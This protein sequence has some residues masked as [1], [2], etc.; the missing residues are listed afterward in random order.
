MC[1]PVA[2]DKCGVDRANLKAWMIC[3]EWMAYVAAIAIDEVIEPAVANENEPQEADETLAETIKDEN[4]IQEFKCVE[5]FEGRIVERDFEAEG[6]AEEKDE[7]LESE[8]VAG[9]ETV[10][11]GRKAALQ[12]GQETGGGTRPAG[13]PRAEP[14]GHRD[15]VAERRPAALSDQCGDRPEADGGALSRRQHLVRDARPCMIRCST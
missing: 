12:D 6:L 5:G 13:R 14:R 10:Q 15:Q 8:A 3:E 9:E 1:E 7:S 4:L 2:G 11:V